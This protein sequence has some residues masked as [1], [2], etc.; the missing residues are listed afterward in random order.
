VVSKNKKAKAVTLPD[1]PDKLVKLLGHANGWVRDNAQQILIDGKYTQAVPALRQAL[2]QTDKPL[3]VMHALWT[4]EGLGVLQTE[5]VLAS[6]KQPVWPI[7]MQGLSV[8]PSVVNKTNYRQFVPVLE[9]MVAS[10]DTLAAPYIAYIANTVQAYDKA[11]A[12]NLL[13]QVVKQYPDNKYVAAAVISNLQDREEAFQSEVLAYA[14][15]TAF[16]VNKQLQRVVTNIRSAKANSDAKV[17]LKDFPKGAAM[18]ASSCQTCHGADGNGVKS[19]APPLNQS[20]WV[21]GD[22]AKLISIVLYGL[23]G[24]VEVNGHLYKAPEINGDMPGI[25]YDKSLANEDVAQLLSFIRKSWRNNAEEVSAEEVK[26][27]REKLKDRQ[28]AFT[29]AELNMLQ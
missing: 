1:N 3:L 20:E 12:T 26:Q 8:L 24:P 6:L 21:T 2:K 9:Q 18:Y 10:N 14:P 28:K 19:L 7:R 11:A 25:G 29:V 4:L 17:L 23:T 16:A 27:V 22:K 5:E 15:D 13:Q